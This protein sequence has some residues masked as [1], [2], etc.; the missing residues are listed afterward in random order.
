ML[1]FAKPFKIYWLIWYLS[2][3]LG[4]FCFW[5]LSWEPNWYFKQGTADYT[6]KAQFSPQPVFV[7][8]KRQGWSLLFK[9]IV[10]KNK[11]PPKQNQWQRSWP[12]KL[13]ILA[14]WPFTEVY[15][16]WLRTLFLWEG[17]LSSRK[18][19]YEI[20]FWVITCF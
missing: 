15:G 8:L 19:I 14:I 4:G 11:Q 17:V 9:K 7:Q 16:P 1:W 18:V 12:A 5:V 6:L 20:G 10:N 13:K 2:S 3:I